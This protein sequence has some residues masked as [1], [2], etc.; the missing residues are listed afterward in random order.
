MFYNWIEFSIKG[1]RWL[2]LM[3]FMQVLFCSCVHLFILMTLHLIGRKRQITEILK[4]AAN[5]R[6][7]HDF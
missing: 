1:L 3:G 7:V 4:F 6:V 2:L 5:R